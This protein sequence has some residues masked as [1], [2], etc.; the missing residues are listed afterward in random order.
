MFP[1]WY[2]IASSIPIQKTPGYT[3]SIPNPKRQKYPARQMHPE[4]RKAGKKPYKSPNP[5][6]I[7]AEE[8]LKNAANEVFLSL[9]LVQKGCCVIMLVLVLA[10]IS[11]KRNHA[12]SRIRVDFITMLRYACLP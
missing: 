5:R 2:N 3:S 8:V 6:R 1:F 11:V 4:T 10:T 12:T 7:E 9:V